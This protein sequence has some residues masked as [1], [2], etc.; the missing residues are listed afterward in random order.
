[1]QNKKKYK[2]RQNKRKTERKQ[3][4]KEKNL[5]ALCA[6]SDVTEAHSFMFSFRLFT[7]C[8]VFI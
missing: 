2:Q 7:S 3:Q 4:K 5:P 8:A 6:L 1:M